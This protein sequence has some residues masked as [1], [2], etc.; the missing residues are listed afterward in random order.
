A[1]ATPA[2]EQQALAAVADEA[3]A[4]VQD[5]TV[6]VDWSNA[7]QRSYWVDQ[8]TPKLSSTI[9]DRADANSSSSSSETSDT[10]YLNG[11]DAALTRPFMTGFNTSAVTVYWVGFA[12]IL[13]AFVLSWFFKAPPL[14][15][16]SA[17]QEQADTAG[18]ADD[19]ELQAVAA[20]DTMGSPTAPTTGSIRVQHGRSGD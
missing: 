16:S 6:S 20:A 19:L 14:R 3:H 17:L 9:E 7:S 1:A 13:L 18:T 5:G 15:K 2:A 11:A 4:T 8:L 12:V 10:S